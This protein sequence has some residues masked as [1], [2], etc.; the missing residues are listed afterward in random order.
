MN[1]SAVSLLIGAFFGTYLNNPK[2]KSK[3]DNGLRGI[4]GKSID[5]LNNLGKPESVNA[6]VVQPEEPEE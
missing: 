6:N 3:V 5:A 4:M 1:N 2:F